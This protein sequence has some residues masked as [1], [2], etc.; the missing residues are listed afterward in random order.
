MKEVFLCDLISK[1][2]DEGLTRHY[3]VTRCFVY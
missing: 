1:G 2:G 3:K